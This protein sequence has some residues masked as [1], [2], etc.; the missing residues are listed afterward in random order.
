MRCIVRSLALLL[1]CAAVASCGGARS[2]EEGQRLLTEGD[3]DRG[4][5]KLEAAMRANPGNEKYRQL[6]ERERSLVIARY[7]SDADLLRGSQQY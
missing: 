1:L 4:L 3:N 6:Y 2:Y 7:V 5:A